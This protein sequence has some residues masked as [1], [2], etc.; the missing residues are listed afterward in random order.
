MHPEKSAVMLVRWWNDDGNGTGEGGDSNWL[1]VSKAKILVASSSDKSG[2]SNGQTTKAV[3]SEGQQQ[4]YSSL[5]LLDREG[6][7]QSL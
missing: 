2:L 5:H 4:E 3:T 1:D 7:Q 6:P